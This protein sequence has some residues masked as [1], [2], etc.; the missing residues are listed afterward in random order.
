MTRY[1]RSIAVLSLLCLFAPGCGDK[2]STKKGNKK[3]TLFFPDD[4]TVK[5][6]ESVTVPIKIA[7]ENMTQG[8]SVRFE[9]IPTGVSTENSM[10]YSLTADSVNC[11]FRAGSGAKPVSGQEVRVMVES[12]DGMLC[13]GVL[14]LT[15][16]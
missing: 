8:V 1:F 9:N 11:T 3:L 4:A 2:I 7:R 6:G 13:K 10:Q 16:K 5:V 14:K 12:V 15:V